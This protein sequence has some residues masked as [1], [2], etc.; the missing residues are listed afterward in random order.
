MKVFNLNKT[1]A[2]AF[3]QVACAQKFSSKRMMFYAV[4]QISSLEVILYLGHF[5]TPRPIQ[6][7]YNLSIKLK[8]FVKS[9][10]AKHLIEIQDLNTRKITLL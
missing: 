4:F 7:A 3:I 5:D 10:K 9:L 2:K 8:H 6:N 1:P